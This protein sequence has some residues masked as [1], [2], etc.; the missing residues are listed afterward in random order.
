MSNPY[1]AAHL[2]HFE[3]AMHGFDHS[4]LSRCAAA[5]KRLSTTDLSHTYKATISETELRFADDSF[6][7]SFR[8]ESIERFFFCLFSMIATVDVKDKSVQLAT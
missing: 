2:R 6:V 8:P 4:L 3:N 5:Q 1:A 7:A